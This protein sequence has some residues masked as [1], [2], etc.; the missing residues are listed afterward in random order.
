MRIQDLLSQYRIEYREA[1]Q[2]HH[3]R[4]GWI[5]IDCPFCG[6]GTYKFHLG[7][8]LAYGYFS[9]WKCGPHPRKEVWKRL[10]IPWSEVKGIPQ[11]R[12]E[13]KKSYVNPT[14][15]EPSFRGPLLPP[16]RKYLESRGFDP[17][18]IVKLWH[19]E[20]IGIAPRLSWRIYIPIYWRSERVSWTTRAIGESVEPRYLSAS[21]KEERIPH[22]DLVYGIDFCSHSIVVVEGPF[23]AWRIGPGAGALF[24][25]AFTEAQLQKISKIPYRYICLD[26]DAQLTA[27]RLADQLSVFPG[28][29]WVIQLDAKDPASASQKEINRLRK[30]AKL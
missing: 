10:G 28:Q 29:T 7:Y 22:K 27:E 4:V 17:E 11:E 26:A 1:G 20:G 21:A 9:C 8:N 12:T 14:L 19:V 2:H 18:E 16:H 5:Q 30:I 6:P 13:E 15:M 23:D 3:A 24:G 25:A